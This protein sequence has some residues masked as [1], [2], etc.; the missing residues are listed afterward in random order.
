MKTARRLSMLLVGLLLA[1]GLM[2]AEGLEMKWRNLPALPD[3]M[4]FA[5]HFAGVAGDALLLAGGSNFSGPKNWAQGGQK[6]W[7]DRIFMLDAADS[8]WHE[9]GRLP[10][11][12]GYGVSVTL[13]EGLLC[14]GGANAGEHRADVFLIRRKGEAVEFEDYPALPMPLA[15]ACGAVLDRTIYVA[16]GRE[17]PEGPI[18]PIFLA[19]DLDRP[20]EQRAWRELEPWPGRARIL[21][22]VGVQAG[23]FYLF[24]GSDLVANA[25]GN[26]DWQFLRESW[27]FRPGH[28]WKRIADMPFACIAAPS[29]MPAP[30]AAHLL[31]LGGED[32]VLVPQ[33]DE[34]KERHPGFSPVIYAYDTGRD[35]WAET[36]RLRYE[37][38]E[39]PVG[40]PN[41]GTWPPIDTPA[42]AWHGGWVLAN[43][44]VRPGTRTPRVLFGEQNPRV[45]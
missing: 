35:H 34:L 42:V 21:A 30:D 16:G 11:A 44:E 28:G 40:R 31:L 4:G 19:L 33:I 13:P 37:P 38:G 22:C 14:I 8:H 7:H 5:G 17:T 1:P 6:V 26:Y 41:D 32:D 18:R 36:G 12:L 2:I 25:A 27:C 20:A 23:A 3:L 24:G 45:K 39:D 15:Y 43:G 29:P 10:R 9:A